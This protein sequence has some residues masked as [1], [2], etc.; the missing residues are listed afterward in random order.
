M[1]SMETALSTVEDAKT[2]VREYWERPDTISLRDENLRRLE[3]E[4]IACRVPPGGKLLD[5]G[6]GDGVNT[7]TY[8]GRA[9]R[10]SGVDYSLEMIRRARRRAKVEGI[11]IDFR[12]LSVLELA[13]L[14]ERFDTVVSQ[15]CLINLSTFD[16]QRDALRAIH[17]VLRPGGTYL[18]LECF[19]QGR[20]A[21]NDLRVKVG[22]EPI[23]MPWHNRFLDEGET[24]D[25]IGALFE[26]QATVDFSLYFMTSRVVNAAAGFVPPH[27]DC[28]RLNAAAARLQAAIGLEQSS[29]IGAQRLL[30]LKARSRSA[31]R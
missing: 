16:E 9:E 17:S 7:V 20:R 24:L 27:P 6:C 1:K 31:N 3:C 8:A 5:V 26:V 23:P 22:L 28:E 19:E 21:L 18:M 4:A 25:E 2:A 29:G 12:N 10:V 11:S 13:S 30:V 15:R 14:G